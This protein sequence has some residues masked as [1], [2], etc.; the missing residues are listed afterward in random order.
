MFF[1]GFWVWITKHIFVIFSMSSS[2]NVFKP[3]NSREVL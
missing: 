3:Q 2:S 1:G